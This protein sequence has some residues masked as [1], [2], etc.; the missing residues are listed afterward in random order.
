MFLKSVKTRKA[1]IHLLS[2]KGFE[3]QATLL[4]TN[5]LV[6]INNNKQLWKI[7]EIYLTRWKCDEYYRYIKKLYKMRYFK[8]RG[9]NS[10]R[11]IIAMT[12]AI[13]YFTS[14]YIEISI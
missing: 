13:A 2:L 1:S 5:K 11:N 14:I 6:N 8:V 12:R 10:I 3:K 7:I 4:Q 9:H